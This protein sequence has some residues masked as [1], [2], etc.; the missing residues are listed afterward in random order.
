MLFP[1][2]GMSVIVRERVVSVTL[3]Y[4]RSVLNPYLI[5]GM[6][7]RASKVPLMAVP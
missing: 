3:E 6:L 7:Q 1:T 4:V 5:F 2:E